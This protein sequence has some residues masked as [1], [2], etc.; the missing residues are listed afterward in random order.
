M[1]ALLVVLATLAM[2]G[3]VSC[4][5]KPA[6]PTKPPVPKVA[7]PVKEEGPVDE[8]GVSKNPE[9]YVKFVEAMERIGA[10]A[11]SI[12][13]AVKKKD[14]GTVIRKEFEKLIKEF[15]ISGD[16]HYLKDDE[17]DDA[18]SA[19]FLLSAEIKLPRLVRAEWNE[20]TYEENMGE[21]K[22]NCS[23]CHSSHRDN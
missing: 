5:D 17:K 18:M 14:D 13:K 7:E 22:L 3:L 2:I 21:L 16:L 20:E 6:E 12:K 10:I 15:K 1:R 11:K 8:R 9:V 4:G 19:L 23:T